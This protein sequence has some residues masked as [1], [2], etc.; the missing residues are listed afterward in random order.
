MNMTLL[1]RMCTLDD[2]HTTTH[3]A[4]YANA[5]RTIGLGVRLRADADHAATD[6]GARI[7][8]GGAQLVAAGTQIVDVRVH[9]ERTA[10]DVVRTV[11]LDLRIGDVHLADAVGARLDVAQIADVPRGGRRSAVR[12]ALRIEVRPGGDAAVGVVAELVHVEAVRALRQ[13]GD[14]AG[15]GHRT[16]GGLWRKVDGGN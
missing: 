2:T 1:D 4:D 6:A 12:L 5:R 3:P 8:G 16:V 11:Q 7:A 15:H 10:D 9:D 14:L 13:A